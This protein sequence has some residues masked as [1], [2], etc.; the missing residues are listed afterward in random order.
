MSKREHRK[1]Q[2]VVRN[3][4]FRRFERLNSTTLVLGVESWDLALLRMYSK[5]TEASSM[6]FCGCPDPFRTTS[7]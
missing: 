2:A 1:E 5:D 7:L 4:S 6:L 3:V